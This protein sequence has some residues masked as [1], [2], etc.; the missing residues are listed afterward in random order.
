MQCLIWNIRGLRSS[1]S[2]ERLHAFVKE[3][4][5]KILAVLEP[6]IALDQRFM[7]RRLGFQRV[8]SNLSGHIWV[9]FAEDVMAECV[10]DHAQFLHFKVSAPFL[11]VAVFCSFVYAK[12]DYTVRRDLWASLLQVKPDTG[13]W[14]VG[15]DF[16]V[17]RDASEC[18]GSSGGR[19]LPMDEFNDFILESAL[20]DAGFE[21]S[22][23][24]WTNRNIW[25]RLDRV[26]V[27]V[28]WSDHFH[29]IRVEHLSRS[30]SDHCPLLVSAPVFARGPSS[31]RFQSMW[32]RHPGFLQTVRLNWNTPCLL[33]GMPKLFAKLKRLKGHLKWWNRDVFGNVFDRIAEAEKSVRL[34]EAACEANPSEHCWNLL[35]RCNEDLAR[36]TAMEA[37]FWKQKAAFK[38]LEDGERNTKLFHNM[39]KKKHVA[40]K[41]FRIWEDGTCLTSPTLIQQSGAVYFQRLLTGD[42]FVLALPDFAGFSSDISLE[43]NN[44][45]AAFPSLEEVRS[46]VFSIPRE[47][48]AGP[49]GYSSIFFQHCWDFVQQDVMDA[50]LDFFGGSPL[51][52][53]FTATTITLIPKVAGAQA[54]TDFRPISLCNVSNKIISKLLYSWLS[55]VVGRLISQNQSGFV[56]GRMIADNILLAQELTHS[57][58]LP[59]RGGNVILKLDMAKAYDRVQWSFLLDVLRQFGFFEQVV[60][61]VRACISFCKFSVN[62]NGTPASFFGSARGLRQGDPLSPLLFILGAEYL[63]RGLDR[64]FL[65]NPDLRYRSGCNLSISH[66]AYADDVIIFANGGSR[67][68]QC[69]KDFLAHYENCSGQL[70]NVAKSSMIFPSGCSARRRSRLLR[71][72]GFAEGQLPLRYLGAPLFRGNRKCSLFEP[73]L[74]SVRKKLE[75]WELRSLA[76]GSRMTLIRSVLLSIPIFL[77]Q[78][79][80]PPLAV[81]ERLELIFNAFLWGS[82]PLE[83]KWHWARW[84]R[85]CLPVSEGGLGFRR[86]KDIVDSFSM[87]LWF[88]CR[89]G[90]SLWAR[91]LL[92]KYCRSVSP[93]CAPS[94]GVISPTWRRLLQIRPRAEPGIR[95]RIGGG[96]VSF[97]DDIWLGDTTLSS[98]CDV[99]DDRGTCVSSFL[100]EGA[101]DFDTL[102]ATV[103][104]ALAEEIAQVPVLVDEPDAALWIHSSDGAFSVRSAWEQVRPRGQ[105]LDILTP[106]WGRWMRPTM[107][108]FLWRF[109]HRWLPVDEVLQRR[110]F[111]LASKCQCCERS[112]MLTHVFIH[113]PIA[114]SVWHFFGAIFRVRIPD[115]EDFRLFLSIWKRG[116]E[117]S[118][119]GNVKE[120]LPF[121]VLWFLWTAH[122][123]VKHRHLSPSAETVKFQILSYLRLAHSAATIKPR[124]WLGVS[125]AARSMGISVG[126]QRTK[127]TAVVRWLRP[128]PGFFKLNVD[129]SSR[130]NPGESSV[131]GV[132]RDSSGHTLGFFSE[133][134]GPGSNVRA[135]LW[136]VWRGVLFCSDHSLFPLWIETDSQI[137]IQIL[138]S[139]RVLAFFSEFIG[140]GSNVRAELWAI[141]RGILLCSDLSLFPLWIETDSQIAIQILRSR[142]CR[143]DLDHIVSRTCVLVRNRPVHFSHIYR[144]GNSVADALARQAHDHRYSSP[145]LFRSFWS[146]SVPLSLDLLLQGDGSPGVHC[147]SPCLV[148]DVVLM[149]CGRSLVPLAFWISSLIGTLIFCSALDGASLFLRFSVGFDFAGL[150]LWISSRFYCTD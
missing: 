88:R 40:N 118:P 80:Q 109:W 39:V 104:S 78:V 25:K 75:G 57:L 16:N 89:Q 108:F 91:L 116:R 26:F 56:P 84:S 45:I 81:L 47:S 117:W 126:F 92:R 36:I 73:L 79:I 135:E 86:L 148:L 105:V 139:R 97:W 15:G 134:I 77:C 19:Q 83:K 64:L 23:F 37:D 52:Q 61:M 14:L 98:R 11:P 3:K 94:R 48:V 85:A 8:F 119:G 28:D 142:R 24:T 110:G 9:F 65:Q 42:P 30:V 22:S 62:I 46:V 4:S 120:F 101:W 2:Q 7:V 68:M 124:L 138:R 145:A 60:R 72:T 12:C 147:A 51:P 87:K 34:A 44:R 27:S 136:A 55:S 66:L 141:W 144:E 58:N 69:L 21:G 63:S 29:S 50:V 122:N 102:C 114:R 74:Q 82:R 128:P 111:S 127:K 5:V 18:L 35:S 59:S 130:G 99:R 31:F 121:V 38:W 103:P 6:M 123:D 33:Q 10:F 41:I 125:Q 95:W 67:G 32:V 133:F 93:V 76:P 149:F 146:L 137:A 115:T 129:G 1:E 113:S 71:I 90:T 131:G 49:D 100:L 20:V 107:S 112:E 70:V 140:L 54:W 106:C 150:E 17:V 53:G 43:E 96:E 132:V 143:W 13:P